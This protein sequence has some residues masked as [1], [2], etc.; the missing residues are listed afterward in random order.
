MQTHNTVDEYIAGQPREIRGIL[1][2]VRA[3]IRETAPEAAEKISYGM[4]AYAQNG[5]LVYFGAQKRH[6]GFY[7]TGEGMEAFKDSFAGYK[8]SKGAVQFP[9]D[10]PIPYGLITDIVKYRVLHN[11]QKSK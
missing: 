1:E 8:T 3:V 4:P 2:K 7:P 6:L 11:V 10:K 9:Y 5:I